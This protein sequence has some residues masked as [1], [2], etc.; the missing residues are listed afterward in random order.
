MRLYNKNN[1]LADETAANVICYKIKKYNKN[2]RQLYL[3][4]KFS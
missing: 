2:I 3:Y 1:P 4:V